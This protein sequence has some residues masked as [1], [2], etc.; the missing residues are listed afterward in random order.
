MPAP[1]FFT[2]STATRFASATAALSMTAVVSLGAACGSDVEAN[3]FTK[4]D[5][6][7][8]TNSDVG[9]PLVFGN[10][11]GSKNGDSGGNSCEAIAELVAP[12]PLHLV[13]ALDYS[14][15]MIANEN[16]VGTV[17]RFVAV[18]DAWIEYAKLPQPN[19]VFASFVA[20]GLTPKTNL[21]VCSESTYAPILADTSMPNQAAVT[22]AINSIP[23]A[24][25]NETPTT[26]G[27]LSS[28]RLARELKAQF[29]KDD[30]AIVLSTDGAPSM[31][32]TAGVPS[33]S[34]AE[35]GKDNEPAHVAS[36]ITA[37]Q[38]ASA[39]GFK[40]Y[41]V[42]VL[43]GATAA[44]NTVTLSK[45]AVAGGTTAATTISGSSTAAAIAQQLSD[46]LTAVG[47]EFQCKLALSEDARN[48]P[49][50][51][52]VGYRE[53]PTSAEVTLVYAQGCPSSETRPAYQYDNAANPTKVVLCPAQ[54]TA[55][56]SAEKA[57]IR[58]AT[59]CNPRVQ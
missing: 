59:G 48:N 20:F 54:C 50:E 47:R 44:D 4:P 33:G 28:L 13:V 58:L 41:V 9:K 10:G 51:T 5:S 37:V 42:G 40:T 26:G 7:S 56:T 23:P 35:A 43:G 52:N 16:K 12:P 39:E 32:G 18:R 55:F 17:T 27:V 49:S 30:V 29:P 46:R 53:S 34:T 6:G 3:T 45:L 21:N 11:D 15:S 22:A 8:T 19:P 31:C 14:G 38:K 25:S 2:R 36:A 57:Q 1:R 24:I